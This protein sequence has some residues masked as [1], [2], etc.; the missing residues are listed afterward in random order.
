MARPRGPTGC[1]VSPSAPL[2][3]SELSPC[4]SKQLHLHQNPFVSPQHHPASSPVPG[5]WHRLVPG[6]RCPERARPKRP[7]GSW[8]RIRP[9]GVTAP[10]PGGGGALFF[11]C[12]QTFPARPRLYKE[13]LAPCAGPSAR[14]GLASSSLLSLQALA[15]HSI[16]KPFPFVS[17]GPQPAPAHVTLA[18]VVKQQHK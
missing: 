10:S 5:C 3:L 16:K 4:C 6:A 15:G 1:G 17:P 8:G 13:A 12:L 9:P 11:C 18:T 2:Q 7:R 14:R